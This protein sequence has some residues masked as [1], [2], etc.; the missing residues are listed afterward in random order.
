MNW[1]LLDS[2]GEYSVYGRDVPGGMV[3]VV[4]YQAA[5]AG[6]G[7]TFLP[8]TNVAAIQAEWGNP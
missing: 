2:V 4:T 1:T 6:S 5:A 3:M 7:L 8:G